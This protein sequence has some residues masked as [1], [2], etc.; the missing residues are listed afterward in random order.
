MTPEALEDKIYNALAGPEWHGSVAHAAKL[1]ADVATEH[2][3]MALRRA[4]TL[5]ERST[6]R[7]GDADFYFQVMADMR[8][9]I[10]I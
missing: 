2:Y 3:D 9:I 8:K 6:P 7:A 10:G 5:M 1:A 4:Y